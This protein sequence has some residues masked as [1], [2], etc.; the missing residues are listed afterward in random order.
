MPTEMSEVARAQFL[1]IHEELVNR[2][3]ARARFEGSPLTPLELQQFDSDR[4]SKGEYHKFDE[5]F[6]QRYAWQDF[7]DRM[8]GL[9]RRAIAEDEL[10]DPT[11]GQRYS[12]KV[13]LLEGA[14]ESFTLWACCVPA[15]SGYESNNARSATFV[16]L[17]IVIAI[18]TVILWMVLKSH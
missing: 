9:L 6:Q 18:V 5:E 16:Q 4:M 3:A 15:L 10:K 17:G 11:A 13:H 1:Q 14:P 8:S 7:L 12:E 2:I